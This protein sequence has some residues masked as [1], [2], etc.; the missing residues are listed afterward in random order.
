MISASWEEVKT[1]TVK[2]CFRKAGWKKVDG[3]NENHLQ[4]DEFNEED[5]ISLAILREQLNN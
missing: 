3:E 5:E 2:N 1:Q 4:D